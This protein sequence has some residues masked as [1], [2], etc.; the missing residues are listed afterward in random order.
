MYKGKI[1][2]LPDRKYLT[3]YSSA[4]VSQFRG[5]QEE[6]EDTAQQRNNVDRD[7]SAIN[8]AASDGNMRTPDMTFVNE[9]VGHQRQMASSFENHMSDLTRLHAQQMASQSHENRAELERLANRQADADRKAR[10][11]E[12]ALSGLR[13]V[14]EED[15]ARLARLAESQVL[16]TSTSMLE[17]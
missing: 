12:M 2:K 1:I 9:A 8:R 3:I 4:D 10:M 11:A 7:K 6:M 13:D 15:R 17:R 14:Q 5:I 16:Y